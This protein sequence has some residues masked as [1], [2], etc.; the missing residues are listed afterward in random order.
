MGASLSI[1]L[2]RISVHANT[3]AG[4]PLP[5]ASDDEPEG[6]KAYRET[7]GDER[8]F[9][10]LRRQLR[11]VKGFDVKSSTAVERQLRHLRKR[12]RIEDTRPLIQSVI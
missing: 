4:S 9:I 7:L 5:P 2:I 10:K 6:L 3:S 11:E 1:G 8:A 12:Y